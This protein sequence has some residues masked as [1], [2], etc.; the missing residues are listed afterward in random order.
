MQEQG[1]GEPPQTQE[2]HPLEGQSDHH[3]H[4]HLMNQPPGRHAHTQH[5]VEEPSEE[6]SMAVVQHFCKYMVLCLTCKSHANLN[7]HAF[8]G[9]GHKQAVYIAMLCSISWSRVQKA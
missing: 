2:A 5:S 8:L 1:L 7:K 9:A 6:F 4:L 3:L